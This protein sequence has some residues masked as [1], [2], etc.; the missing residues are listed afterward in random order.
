MALGPV[1]HCGDHSNPRDSGGNDGPLDAENPG[2]RL[3]SGALAYG[4]M[5]PIVT[6]VVT[7]TGLIFSPSYTA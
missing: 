7:A 1:A 4:Y 6:G 5:V 2:A 3:R